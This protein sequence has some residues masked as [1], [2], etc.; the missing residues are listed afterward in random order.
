MHWGYELTEKYFLN[1]TTKYHIKVTYYQLNREEILQKA[2]ERYSKKKAS[3][4][5]LKN[6]EASK[7]GQKTDT[8]TCHKKEKARLR[9]TKEISIKN[10]FSIKKKR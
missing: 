7:K 6:K 4:Y 1:E 3:E 2:K 5:Y 10:W 9:S 8:K